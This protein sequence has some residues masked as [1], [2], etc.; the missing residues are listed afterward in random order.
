SSWLTAGLRRMTSFPLRKTSFVNRTPFTKGRQTLPGGSGPISARCCWRATRFFMWTDSDFSLNRRS[1]LRVS[2]GGLGSLALSHLLATESR[3]A[4]TPHSALRIPH[5]SD[6]P[7][8]RKTP[9]HP[10]R[11]KAETCL[12]QPAG[13]RQLGLFVP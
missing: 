10:P 13:P 8:A 6:S 3:A 1:F 11:A 4:E 7:L 9:H 5:S 12:L 2:A